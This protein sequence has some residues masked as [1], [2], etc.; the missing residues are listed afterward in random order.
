MATNCNADETPFIE[1][2]LTSHEEVEISSVYSYY[3][4][5]YT[6]YERDRYNII[7]GINIRDMKIKEVYAQFHT[8]TNS[9][10]M[11]PLSLDEVNNLE[12]YEEIIG[13]QIIRT[14]NESYKEL[15]INLPL[16]TENKA[17]NEKKKVN[18][19]LSKKSNNQLSTDEENE[20]YRIIG[21]RILRYSIL[22]G[23]ESEYNQY[24]R[25]SE[26][27]SNVTLNENQKKAIEFEAKW[28]EYQVTGRNNGNPPFKIMYKK[29]KN[30]TDLKSYTLFTVG[31]G[32][33][34]D[35]D[36]NL[37]SYIKS[38]NTIFDN[39]DQYESKS[40][41]ITLKLTENKVELKADELE[42][43]EKNFFV[44]ENK[45]IYFQKEYV[46]KDKTKTAVDRFALIDMEISSKDG[47]TTLTIS[48]IS[49]IKSEE[50]NIVK[51]EN[52]VVNNIETWGYININN[53]EAIQKLKQIL[54][55]NDI[56]TENVEYT[57]TFTC[58]N[59]WSSTSAGGDKAGFYVLM[60]HAWPQN[61]GCYYP[62]VRK[63]ENG[64]VSVTI[65]SNTSE[66]T[67]AF[68]DIYYSLP[69]YQTTVD[70]SSLITEQGIQ[71]LENKNVSFT[72]TFAGETG[73]TYN[74]I[75]TREDY[76]LNGI[77]IF[78][79]K[80]NGYLYININNFAKAL[81]KSDIVDFIGATLD[82]NY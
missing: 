76:T 68:N 32:D 70:I 71:V 60:K 6:R 15:L 20:L 13:K 1:K 4:F 18:E 63:S 65:G 33:M 43:N 41:N 12:K 21:R 75:I 53:D 14:N 27:E 10:N 74:G 31:Y 49:G 81:R 58:K 29:F 3:P 57:I 36:N 26:K 80:E 54:T 78:E 22:K 37:Y 61:G 39:A 56:K 35:E 40:G 50:N 28:N 42:T 9:N 55:N 47:K 7:D 45:T 52:Q 46:E 2:Y 77:Y 30:T 38:N 24:L 67:S 73:K 23:E 51:R 8:K 79:R 16:N 17:F 11:T 19:L 48:D 62:A 72:V 34:L 64:S 82:I 59:P 25:D 44:N 66:L 69:S 5:H